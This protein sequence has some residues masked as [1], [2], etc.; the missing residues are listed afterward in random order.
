I[1]RMLADNIDDRNMRSPGV[2]QV[3]QTIAKTWTKMKQRAGGFPSHAC[4]SVGRCRNN[5]FEQSQNATHF[6]PLVQ[7][8]DD[9]HFRSA[10]VCEAG[11]DSSGY[12]CSNQT[13]G[14]VHLFMPSENTAPRTPLLDRKKYAPARLR[15]PDAKT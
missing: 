3:S 9:V 2:V 4:I 11:V 8:R 5:A 14:S 15:V 7:R 12:Q 6:R 1:G 13:L 10:G